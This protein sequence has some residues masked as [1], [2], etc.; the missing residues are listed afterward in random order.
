MSIQIHS[1]KVIVTLCL[2]WVS[3]LRVYGNMDLVVTTT[4][5]DGLYSIS[6]HSYT[7]HYSQCVVLRVVQFPLA[8]Q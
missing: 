5:S 7:L 1:E 6:M 8:Y 3:E 2:P 4:P